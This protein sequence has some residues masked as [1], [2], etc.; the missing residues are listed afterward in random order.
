M[1]T[2]ITPSS[3]STY[4]GKYGPYSVSI[5]SSNTNYNFTPTWTM[6]ISGVLYVTIYAHVST[7][8]G[9]Y[10]L[11][12]NGSGLANMTQSPAQTNFSPSLTGG[13]S[14]TG[15]L[16][17]ATGTNTLVS[18]TSNEE[19]LGQYAL[20]MIVAAGDVIGVTTVNT[21]S[22]ATNYLDSIEFVIV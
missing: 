19:L 6:P 11:S 21:T 2:I 17:C 7:G 12:R 15:S 10:S 5:S 9:Y 22:S 13:V 14:N 8:T 3:S 18:T 1:T 16:I 20:I 4:L